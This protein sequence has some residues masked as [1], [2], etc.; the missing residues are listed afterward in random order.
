MPTPAARV[1]LDYLGIDANN[2]R[3]EIELIGRN[4]LTA[5][6]LLLN[7]INYL[8][9]TTKERVNRKLDTTKI[10]PTL[11][12]WISDNNKV[13]QNIH[14]YNTSLSSVI[15]YIEQQR[16]DFLESARKLIQNGNE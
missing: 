12:P 13:L 2:W 7:S 1:Y 11:P 9:Q 4:V 3:N 10:Y 16:N 8:S 14:G 5:M 15:N 6:R